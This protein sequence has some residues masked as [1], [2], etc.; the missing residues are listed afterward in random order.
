MVPATVNTPDPGTVDP[1][2]LLEA[3]LYSVSHDLRS[4]LL[5]LSLAGELIAESL[6]ARLREDPSNSGLVALDALQH[7]ARDLE[8][9]LQAL[10]AISRARRRP[11]E[12]S[13]A[14]LRMLLGGH[15][16]ISDDG[17]LGGRL[18]SVDPIAVREIIDT[19]CGEEPTEIHVRLTDDFAVLRLPGPEAL[20]EVRGAPLVTLVQSLQM[21]AGTLVESLAAAQV[22]TERLGGRVEVD[23]NGVQLWLPRFEA[24]SGSRT[25]R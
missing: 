7:G 18:V 6:G 5:T 9:M 22:V 21:H 20:A 4:P 8:R 19:V 3:L 25:D 10:T 15:V 1:D 2:L 24:A 12:A 17:D 11:L 13:G 16:V 14:P 23:G